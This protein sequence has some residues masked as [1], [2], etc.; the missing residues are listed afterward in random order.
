[1]EKTEAD[2]KS[3]PARENAADPSADLLEQVRGVI[4]LLSLSTIIFYSITM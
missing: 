2:G 1:M 4:P 3:K